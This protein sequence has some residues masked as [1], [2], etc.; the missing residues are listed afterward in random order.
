MPIQ[1]EVEL[2][3]FINP[4]PISGVFVV[5]K[6]CNVAGIPKIQIITTFRCL[7]LLNHFN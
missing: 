2:S 7:P 4:Y 3:S 6:E 1:E 5:V